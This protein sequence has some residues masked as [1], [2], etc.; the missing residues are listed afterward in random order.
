CP[1]LTPGGRR[2][3]V[4]GPRSGRVG[5][6]HREHGGQLHLAFFLRP[7]ASSPG[8]LEELAVDPERLAVLI[9]RRLGEDAGTPVDLDLHSMDQ[10][11]GLR[12]T[13]SQRTGGHV[14]MERPAVS[15]PDPT[16]GAILETT[17]RD[18]G[19]AVEGQRLVDRT[20]VG[21]SGLTVDRLDRASDLA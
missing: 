19:G 21:P 14:D 11:F 10:V 1:D 7:F 17:D 4:V 15:E 12:T 2:V 6:Q 13:R 9:E 3:R 20:L 8:G 5:P 18:P 16:V